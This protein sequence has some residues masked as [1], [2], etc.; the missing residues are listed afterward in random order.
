[1]ICL[2]IISKTDK[3]LNEAYLRK[4]RSEARGRRLAILKIIFNAIFI[5]TLNIIITGYI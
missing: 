5:N 1:M 2:D 4:H 3:S